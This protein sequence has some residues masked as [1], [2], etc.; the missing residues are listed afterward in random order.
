MKKNKEHETINTWSVLAI[1]NL[2]L[3]NLQ[4]VE[5]ISQLGGVRMIVATILQFKDE[6]K[7]QDLALGALANMTNGTDAT[8]LSNAS[9]MVSLRGVEI[10]VR[11]MRTFRGSLSIQLSGSSLLSTIASLDSNWA[12]VVLGDGGLDATLSSMIAFRSSLL[13]QRNG[14][15][16]MHTL[17]LLGESGRAKIVA[18]HGLDAISVALKTHIRD[19]ALVE[20]GVLT[21]RLLKS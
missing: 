10:V 1:R 4:N 16:L 15:S 9:T 6:Q 2:T 11:A 19:E 18:A 8:S 7:M 14:I 21:R 12:H 20:M 3:N 5:T 17:L 13:L